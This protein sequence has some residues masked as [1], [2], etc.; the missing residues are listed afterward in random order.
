MKKLFFILLIVILKS[1]ISLDIYGQCDSKNIIIRTNPN[2]NVRL[3]TQGNPYVE[4]TTAYNIEKPLKMNYYPVKFNWTANQRY[5]LNSYLLPNF[6]D[7][8]NPFFNNDGEYTEQFLDDK[9]IYSLQGW[10]LIRRNFG[11]LDNGDPN[12]CGYPWFILYNKYRGLLRVFVS[13]VGVTG[14][15]AM[16]ISLY[17]DAGGKESNILSRLEANE[18]F[19]ALDVYKE[20]VILSSVFPYTNQIGDWHYADFH[21]NYDPCICMFN[22]QL[23][24]N[25]HMIT[26]SEITLSGAFEASI[27]ETVN[28][29]VIVNPEYRGISFSDVYGIGTKAVQAYRTY[30]D[31]VNEAKK[32]I[33]GWISDGNITNE[34]GE[35]TKTEVSQ[36]LHYLFGEN[37][38]ARQLSSIAG[39]IGALVSVFDLLTGGGGSSTSTLKIPPLS[40]NG[41]IN[42]NGSISWTGNYLN[43]FF[44]TPGSDNLNLND[45]Q[46]PYYNQILGT[47]N[48]MK[49][50]SIDINT[51]TISLC[52]S[53]QFDTYNFLNVIDIADTIR[54]R[55]SENLKYVINPA[56]FKTNIEDIELMAQFEFEVDLVN[57]SLSGGLQI[58]SNYKSLINIKDNIYR[59]PLIPLQCLEN[60]TIDINFYYYDQ[61]FGSQMTFE[62]VSTENYIKNLKLKIIGK[63]KRTD[64]D[65]IQGLQDVIEIKSFKVNQNIIS[66]QSEGFWGNYFSDYPNSL[67][68]E[69]QVISSDLVAWGDITIG[70]NVTTS[71]NGNF[72]ITSINGSINVLPGST[73]SPNIILK[74]GFETICNEPLYPP[75]SSSEINT[76]C[77]SNQ[78]GNYR[79]SLRDLK[80]RRDDN[81]LQGRGF[82]FID[83]FSIYPNPADDYLTIKTSSN[84][85]SI[86]CKIFSLIGEY[87]ELPINLIS[88]GVFRIDIS[89][90]SPGVYFVK[91][92]GSNGACSIVEK[93]VKM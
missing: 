32:T 53:E 45:F 24:V 90:L 12:A 59:T 28:N 7:Y 23:Q 67:T 42:L 38:V 87:Y 46:Y 75:V 37:S 6:N 43:A 70:D 16:R 88:N 30:D 71:N 34:N 76:F 29:Q 55:L 11:F 14:Y 21:M 82:S 5:P 69:N 9:D 74:L 19:Y 63:F 93:F 51:N 84:S 86:D 17:H 64:Y 41:S 1:I 61:F 78:A 81:E 39:P 89:N 47:F 31:A 52:S 2:G 26:S 73:L 57:E 83:S 58:T 3:D 66:S 80:T 68:I 65:N 25:V 8:T 91:I 72:T 44:H 54:F 18:A 20:D 49:T 36:T 40:I 48:L 33:D 77:Q 79:P 92:V 56:A 22:S 13:I 35:K 10:E 15:N 50:P 4:D 62:N 27:T 85:Q 60:E